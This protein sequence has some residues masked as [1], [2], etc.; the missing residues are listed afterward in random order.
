VS[1]N[2]PQMGELQN[3]LRKE[4]LKGPNYKMGS[5]NQGINYFSGDP[6]VS[7]YELYGE[8]QVFRIIIVKLPTSIFTQ[9]Y[10]GKQHLFLLM[11]EDD[12]MTGS[13]ISLKDDITEELKKILGN[14][15]SEK[16]IRELQNLWAGFVH[17][18]Y[19]NNTL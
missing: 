2:E 13:S 12:I 6:T 15:L 18:H 8:K 10:I 19:F 7:Y 11:G 4:H 3:L 1:K 16:S 17:D 9:K 14:F 5:N